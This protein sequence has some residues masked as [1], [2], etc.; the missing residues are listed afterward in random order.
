MIATFKCWNNFHIFTFSNFH[1]FT[2]SNFPI[3]QIVKK[4]LYLHPQSQNNRVLQGTLPS[5]NSSVGRARPCQGRG[6]EFE[7]RFPLHKD[8]QVVEW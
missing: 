3:F 6:R 1:I 2:F 8:A 7:S 5:G 4:F